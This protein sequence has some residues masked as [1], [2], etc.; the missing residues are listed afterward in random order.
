MVRASDIR[1]VSG[2]I[3]P[4]DLFPLLND[5]SSHVGLVI[6][7]LRILHF[8]SELLAAA[9]GLLHARDTELKRA[10]ARRFALGDELRR[11]V[12]SQVLMEP[13]RPLRLGDV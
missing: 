13:A 12:R 9:T 11:Y 7:L 4:E 5:D 3:V 8:K 1:W 2:P 10:D 6:A